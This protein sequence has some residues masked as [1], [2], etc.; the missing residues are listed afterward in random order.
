[1]ATQQGMAKQNVPFAAHS[2]YWTVRP[3]WGIASLLLLIGFSFIALCQSPTPNPLI[4]WSDRSLF[5]KL[6]FPIEVNAGRRLQAAPSRM[7]D[8]FSLDDGERLWAVGEGGAI[9]AST[10]GGN[11][12]KS[13]IS[14]V[15]TSLS[16]VHFNADGK[17][18]WAAG[19]GGTLLNTCDGGETWVQYKSEV[20]NDLSSLHFKDDG[21]HGWVVG[22]GGMILSTKNEGKSWEEQKSGDEA[23]LIS[24]TFNGDGLQGWA[25]GGG[26][27]V[28]STADGGE[29]WTPQRKNFRKN[30]LS[31]HFMPDGRNG[32]SVGSDGEIL[33]T[34]D[35]GSNWSIQLSDFEGTLTSV[36][37]WADGK[38]GWAVGERGT[39]LNTVDGGNKWVKQ[40]SHVGSA[41]L[42]VQ[43]TGDG[44]RGW[45]V[46]EGGTILGTRDSGQ[47]WMPLASG[48]P[49]MLLSAQF[50]SDGRRGWL[51]G[52][53]GTIL[54]TSDGG[55]TWAS[56][57]SGVTTD[58]WSVHFDSEGQHGWVVGID[59]VILNT[60]NGGQHWE[61]Q[62]K[63]QEQNTRG[64][65]LS[66]DFNRDNRRGWAVGQNGTILSTR[67]RGETWE[68]TIIGGVPHLRSVRFSGDGQRGWAVGIGATILS[69]RDGGH[70]WEPRSKNV[71]IKS[72][73]GKWEKFDRFREDLYSV[74]I[75][76]G[77]L[78]G[79]AVGS[80]GSILS[81]DD[82]GQTWR[83]R[84]S[85]VRAALFSV[86]FS[87]DGKRGWAVGAGGTLLKS[88]DAGV[89]WE[90]IPLK[91]VGASRRSVWV[92]DAQGQNVWVAG[93]A[94]ALQH[95]LDG[96][97][98]WDE[99]IW[100]LRYARYPAPWFLLSLLLV[101]GCWWQA[102]REKSSSVG[103]GA[104]AMVTT[105]E[106]LSSASQDRL[107][108]G[109]LARGIS[110]FLRNTAT[111]PPLTLAVSG[112]WGS[113]KSS[114]MALVC[115]DMRRYGSRPVVF[116]AWHHQK[117][118][119]FLAALLQA[120]RD[121]ALPPLWRPMGWLFRLRLLL[122]RSKKHFVL[123]L[124]AVVAITALAHFIVTHNSDQRMRLSGL[125]ATLSSVLET[126]K[127]DK[128]KGSQK[129]ADT[130]GVAAAATAVQDDKA[131]SVH[132]AS[133]VAQL[134]SVLA[135][136]VALRKALTAFGA[137]PAVLL[138]AT[139]DKFKLRDASALTSFRARF[140]EEFREVTQCLP[141]RMLIVVDDLDRC[142]PESVMEVMEAVNFLV[143]S[144]SCFVMLGMATERVRAAISLPLDAIA[145]EMAD[146]APGASSTFEQDRARRHA[147][148]DAYL[149]KLVNLEIA[150]P[151][152]HEVPP[153]L[154]FHLH[155][156]SGETS[157]QLKDVVR[158]LGRFWPMGAVIACLALGLFLGKLL[159][160]PEPVA[161]GSVTQTA[162]PAPARAASA[163]KMASSSAKEAASTKPLHT[164]PS[165][166]PA[167][168]QP[169]NRLAVG[170]PAVL[171]LI[172]GIVYA[173]FRLR[174]NLNQ[175]RDSIRFV[176]ALEVWMPLV[177][178]KLRTPRGLKRF[179]N[180]VRYL[181]ML[182][183]PEVFD[184]SRKTAFFRSFRDWLCRQMQDST[185]SRSGSTV[186]EVSELAEELI[187]AL[188][189]VHEI[190]GDRWLEVVK[191]TVSE[192]PGPYAEVAE[193][194]AKHQRLGGDYRW[195][196]TEKQ[197][198]SFE[199][200]LKG[201]RVKKVEALWER[202]RPV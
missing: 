186:K 144:G 167:D 65:L 179:A 108:F 93:F 70:T 38:R 174:S 56:Q 83:I 68:R 78:Q 45:I 37:F 69:T 5:S 195:P 72:K 194:A 190:Y 164:L 32:W 109:P 103:K 67:N 20:K 2:S 34:V 97:K 71:E 131:S 53:A 90:S 198:L 112:D 191:Q 29:K 129:S 115:E 87:S 66:V 80:G 170:V 26:G 105:D 39:I 134:L 138:A 46:G 89:S 199:R 62:K 137:D 94:P 121:Q 160:S 75:D 61:L 202:I 148:A 74:H 28:L 51:V 116:N 25:V 183:Q 147:Y 15:Q 7:F 22:T 107:N 12:W 176:K 110:R 146:P 154:L 114:L 133:W 161:P 92:V 152:M 184:T 122:V 3:R 88:V 153:H 100:P 159:A 57:S 82:G 201:L 8:V 142:R 1:M 86:H 102:L 180:R 99:E 128:D 40:Q 181:A 42:S 49:I 125:V 24:V 52:T 81:T 132:V 178:R 17:R 23:D 35:G 196:P 14:G 18:G 165:M 31:V 101:A 77:G 169:T 119:Q 177:S 130:G 85:T 96:G 124:A 73:Q 143:S 50:S 95:T 64:D 9:L 84:D 4:S 47:T 41:L 173:G 136:L 21:K 182:Q 140:S 189:A 192:D 16:S 126:T 44:K 60:I 150:V 79:W 200:S 58:L 120:V 172:G 193:V 123:L 135:V 145:R 157:R 55:K 156:E 76:D 59:G 149:E 158:S 151:G 113:G 117:D 141:Y 171:L 33:K 36:H 27:T 127:E 118:E 104:E 185:G 163:P 187:V 91:D 13:Q 162:L 19:I 11:S 168:E 197:L 175:V 63:A 106:Q 111:E 6:I 54:S 155:D 188:G 166:R 139:A 30:L 43:F 48:D 10:D 98:N